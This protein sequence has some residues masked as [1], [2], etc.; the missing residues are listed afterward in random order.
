MTPERG[1]RGS[2]G[3]GRSDRAA[4][5]EGQPG[6][7]PFGE[8]REVTALCYDLIDSTKLLAHLD[9]EDFQDVIAGFQEQ[10]GA[11]VRAYGGS[12]RETLGDDGGMAFF[13][14]PLPMEDSAT[15]AIQAGLDI[16]QACREL[17]AR[18]GS[19]DLHV[20]IG[21]ATSEVIVQDAQGSTDAMVVGFAPALASRLQALAPPDTVVVSESTRAVAR[22]HFTFQHLG[23][24]TLKGLDE[25]L[26]IWSVKRR[27]VGPS[28]FFASGKLRARMIGRDAELKQ[29][30]KCWDEAA[31][32]HGQAL[33]VEGEAG[34]GKSRML[35]EI[36]RGT[37]GRRGRILLFQCSQRG[38]DSAL[39]PLIDVVRSA[40][41]ASDVGGE[42][43]VKQVGQLMHR[44]G[45]HDPDVIEMIAFAT[46]AAVQSVRIAGETGHQRIR[47]RIIWAIRR[48]IDTW[49]ESGPVIVGIEDL[50]WA[51]P[52]SQDVLKALAGW[53]QTKRIL[54]LCT[55]R[56]PP[57]W[58]ESGPHIHRL[59]LDR[60]QAADTALLLSQ[61][62]STKEGSAIPPEAV[63]LV[64]ERTNGVPLF[65]EEVSQWLASSGEA[66]DWKRA[67]SG[68]R[69]S[70]FEK[71]LSA[72]LGGLGPAK[73]VAQAAAA[74]G[75]EFDEDLLR[76]IVHDIP[77]EH[78]SAS[79]G[80]LV[81][82]NILVRRNVGPVPGYGFR[83]ALIQESLYDSLLRKSRVSLHRQIYEAAANR[84]NGQIRMGAA[85]LAEHADRAGLYV[86]AVT[87]Y[88]AAAKESSRRSAMVEA[89]NLLERA[90][91]IIEKI[92]PG[93]EQER[94]ELAVLAALGPV[95]TSTQGTK[96][97]EACALYERAVEIA[98]R[99]PAS[100]QAGW[101]PIYWGWW[102]TG[103]DFAVQH[104]RA[105]TVIAAL[106][107]VDDPEVQLQA[108]HCVWAIDF[109]MGHH[110]TCIAAVDK[111]LALYQSGRG[112]E[113]LTLYGGHDPRVCG[114][115]Q[116][117]LSLWFK[118]FPRQAVASVE[119]SLQWANEIAHV[120]SL[121]HALDIAAMLHRYR[122]N[123]EALAETTGEM[124]RLTEAHDLHSLA[125]KALI[126]NGW[127]TA[128][129][130]DPHEG[131]RSAE[132]GFAIQRRI[133]TREDFPVYSEMLAE[134]LSLLPEADAAVGV[135][136]EALEE[137][138]RTGHLYWLPELHRRRAQ[139]AAA[140]GAG[141]DDIAASLETALRLAHGQNAAAL[142]VAACETALSL[143]VWERIHTDVRGMSGRILAGVE[144]D[145]ELAP[146]LKSIADRVGA[147]GGRR[148]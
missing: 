100:E 40:S 79:F 7:M 58:L 44:E 143:G 131:R 88:I 23:T 8:R 51:D 57:S 42:L 80:E 148:G 140:L 53:I 113:S 2:S 136:N 134:I 49:C 13:G 91:Q 119:E 130:G 5:R 15:E 101:F 109:N 146:L 1:F 63:T 108:Q 47:D 74:F 102:Y 9:L 147:E 72:R 142:F 76:E 35:H 84:T 125:A 45:V 27:S 71:L 70:S 30:L 83:H 61:L 99:R 18:S 6:T 98:R 94:L 107:D 95:L 90:R 62:W 21:I 133:G 41:G 124:T 118:G 55:S 129:L 135:L 46:G 112:R 122:G 120:G 89:R 31:A 68:V 34:I 77:E 59:H 48:C 138:E 29:A 64:H 82:A 141:G 11:A 92:L 50:H 111:G 110:D 24:R 128:R 56:D 65:L 132:E 78:V 16:V 121:A 66:G 54:L 12:V 145:G 139:L 137:A 93:D 14:Y 36:L 126:F 73:V 37:R 67:L 10:A 33:F 32:G 69:L 85:I 81:D 123:L 127:R 106:R 60:L 87:N 26:P 39:A 20:R 22:R 114:L 3:R 117:G 25:A 38:M 96:H 28:R 75:R 4:G 52:T 103:A 116:K 86:E 115:G 104:E 19:G 17:A 144:Q 105:E 97:P 43:T